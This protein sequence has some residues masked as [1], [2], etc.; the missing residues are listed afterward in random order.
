MA[1]VAVD[2]SA[3]QAQQEQALAEEHA[4]EKV[5]LAERQGERR[6]A[7][8]EREADE[9]ARLAQQQE[10][11]KAQLEEQKLR[12]QLAASALCFGCSSAAIR[13]S[14]PRWEDT[15]RPVVYCRALS[16]DRPPEV[17]TV[18][19]CNDFVARATDALPFNVGTAVSSVKE[20]KTYIARAESTDPD[21][22]ETTSET[23]VERA[24]DTSGNNED[25]TGT[26][27]GSSGDEA[28]ADN[29]DTSEDSGDSENDESTTDA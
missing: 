12:A 17:D 3:L 24:G 19:A 5:A 7:Q 18:F 10:R 9:K 8:K 1:R 20:G 29:S 2:M 4:D 21:E 28:G 26:S 11:E 23:D 15:P 14:L 22:A 6:A 25:A 27:D 16:P 13:V